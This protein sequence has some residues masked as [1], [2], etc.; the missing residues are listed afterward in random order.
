LAIEQYSFIYRSEIWSSHLVWKSNRQVTPIIAAAQRHLWLHL[1]IEKTLINFLETKD[2]WIS[3]SFLDSISSGRY[4]NIDYEFF[5][6]LIIK[7]I[8]E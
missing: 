5:C 7:I 8:S 6:E 3:E 4:L 2:F 1:D